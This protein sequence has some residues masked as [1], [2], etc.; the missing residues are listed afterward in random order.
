MLYYGVPVLPQ[1]TASGRP[2]SV[3]QPFRRS[4]M[5]NGTPCRRGVGDAAPYDYPEGA[6]IP[7]AVSLPGIFIRM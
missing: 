4:P 3:Q 5:R 1:G 7:A 6:K 2:G